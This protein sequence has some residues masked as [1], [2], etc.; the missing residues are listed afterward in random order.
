MNIVTLPPGTIEDAL[1][2]DLDREA[3]AQ[4]AGNRLA[5]RQDADRR[6]IAVMAVAQR[7]HR[8][9]DDMRRRREVGLAD[10]E[11]D[12]V[13]AGAD[14]VRGA[15]EDGEGVLLA[16]ARESGDGRRG[17]RRSLRAF[18]SGRIEGKRRAQVKRAQ[19]CAAGMATRPRREVDFPPGRPVHNGSQRF[20]RTT[21]ADRQKITPAQLRSR[22]WFD[23]PDN[24]GMT[25]LYLERYL[26]Y[27]L[28]RAGA[29][30]RQ[31]DHR[32]RADRLGPLALQPAPSRSRQARPRRHPRGRRHRL[33]VPGATRSRR[34]ASVRPPASTATSPISASSRCST[35]IPL[36]GVVLTDRLRQDHPGL[37][38]GRRDGEHSGDRALCRAD[39]ERLAQRRAHGLRHDRLEGA[40]APRGGRDRLPGVHR[41][42]RLLGA[43]GRPLQHDGHG[44]DH[45]LACRGPR[46]VAAGLRRRSRRRIASAVRSP[47]RPAAASSRWS[48]RT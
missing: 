47:T 48:S 4:V 35:A 29:A 43:L 33:R 25:A 23:N 24:P 36:D 20:G 39:A 37:P 14:Q 46:H 28:T 31:A 5:E 27:G 45:E 18:P 16:D 7:L 1:R 8:R 38:D 30:I 3:P 40:R 34:P 17:M 15:G 6:R 10:A 11:I 26:N 2:R 13:A 21:M 19:P 44:L 41:H 42:R 12:D 22:L 9:L 32:H